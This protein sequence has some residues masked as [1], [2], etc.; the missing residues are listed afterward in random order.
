LS[1]GAG[2]GASALGAP[3]RCPRRR[4][5]PGA[6]SVAAGAGGGASIAPPF[7]A[8]WIASISWPLRMRPVPLMPSPPATCWS[9][10]STMPESPLP[11]RRRV[12][13]AGA[14]AESPEARRKCVGVRHVSPSHVRARR[15]LVMTPGLFPSVGDLLPVRSNRKSGSC[16]T[17]PMRSTASRPGRDAPVDS[18][19]MQVEESFGRRALSVAVGK[20][21]RWFVVAGQ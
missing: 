5:R 12:P 10:A 13:L 19:T 1:A 18:Q 14:S 8:A 21:C 2:R 4:W 17:T 16:P 15:P 3:G 6:P 20:T 7:C 11:L 9:S